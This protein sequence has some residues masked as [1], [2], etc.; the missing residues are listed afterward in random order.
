MKFK[1]TLQPA[2]FLRRYKRFLVDVRFPDNRQ[3]TVYCP[4]TGSMKGC[5]VEGCEVLAYMAE[6]DPG[7]IFIKSPVPVVL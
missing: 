3:I 6:V 4:N 2:I 7:G 5:L 1:E